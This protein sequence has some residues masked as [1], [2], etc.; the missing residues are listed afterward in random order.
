MRARKWTGLRAAIFV[1]AAAGLSVSYLGLAA[2][3]LARGPGFVS[4]SALRDAF[5]PLLLSI[6]AV[7]GVLVSATFWAIARPDR[8][9]EVR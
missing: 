4:W 1:G 5:N 3:L 7:L 8:D 6:S 9:P 2:V